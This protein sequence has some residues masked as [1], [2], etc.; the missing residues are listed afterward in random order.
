MAQKD[1]DALSFIVS[2]SQGFPGGPGGKAPA[3]Q[4]RRRKRGGSVS[5]SRK[6]LWRRA[7]Q[8]SPELLLGE[9]HG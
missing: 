9:S 4:G 5:G 8:P 6:I 3:Y 2:V 1:T 7:W